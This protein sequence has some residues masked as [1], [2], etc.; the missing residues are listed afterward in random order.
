L[1]KK[2]LD[3]SNAHIKT[4]VDQKETEAAKNHTTRLH[5]K[6]LLTKLHDFEAKID[7]LKEA[8]S[9][10]KYAAKSEGEK[11]KNDLNNLRSYHIQ[12]VETVR[13]MVT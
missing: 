2:K 11:L 5:N 12:H 10:L 6:Q 1:I 8:I 4:L 9:D 3:K 7:F 13:K